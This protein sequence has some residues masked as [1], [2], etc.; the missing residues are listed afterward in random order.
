MLVFGFLDYGLSCDHVSHRV[1]KVFFVMV[2]HH[3][4]LLVIEKR[5][6]FGDDDLVILVSF[7]SA[8]SSVRL[9]VF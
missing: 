4:V 8:V 5:T 7:V 9:S 3:I 1:T 2:Y 6:S